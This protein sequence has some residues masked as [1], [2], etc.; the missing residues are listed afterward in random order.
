MLDSLRKF[1]SVKLHT[2][3]PAD[4]GR[5]RADDIHFISDANAAVMLGADHGSHYILLAGVL[6]LITML[7]WAANANIDEVVR[8]NGKV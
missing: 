4:M 8:G 6:F 2:V 7:L 3:Q 5:L 1:T